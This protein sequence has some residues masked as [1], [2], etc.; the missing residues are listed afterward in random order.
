MLWLSL[1]CDS[2]QGEI[3]SSRAFASKSS[4]SAQ[5]QGFL[6]V[7]PEACGIGF[8]NDLDP[9]KGAANRVLFNGSGLALGDLNGDQR[10][11]VFFCAID[12]S[13]ELYINQGDWQFTKH[14]LKPSLADPGI[15]SRGVVFADI[16]GDARLDILLATV[17]R[18]ELT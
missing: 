16:N 1:G 5:S 7:M 14:S 4:D 3:L 2:L 11:D 12:G 10:P 8:R 15:P 13:N 9:L 18:G 6:R 17:G